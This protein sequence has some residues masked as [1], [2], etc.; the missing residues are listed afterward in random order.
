MDRLIGRA[1]GGTRKPTTRLE[2]DVKVDF[3]QLGVKAHVC[4]TPWS[5]QAKRHC[6]QARLGPHGS[7]ISA[8]LRGPYSALGSGR[9]K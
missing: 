4:D 6:E 7:S 3:L 1:T 2:A 9:G 8:G 5:L